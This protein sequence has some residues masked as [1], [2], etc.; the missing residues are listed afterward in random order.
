MATIRFTLRY[1][2]IDKIQSIY[3]VVCVGDYDRLRIKVPNIE[4]HSNQWDKAKG[5]ARNIKEIQNRHEINGLL[6]EMEF[7]ARKAITEIE[8]HNPPA[9]F[10]KIKVAVRKIYPTTKNGKQRPSAEPE[11]EAE[12][13]AKMT[14][15]QFVE[16][17]MKDLVNRV[18]ENGKLTKLQTV[19]NYTSAKNCLKE[20]EV[21]KG[22]TLDFHSFDVP[23]IMEYKSY[24]TTE[25][26]QKPNTIGKKIS[27]IKILLEAAY[28]LDLHSNT[29]YKTKK[30]FRVKSENVDN[31]FMTEK[32]LTTIEN[33]DFSANESLD[34]VRDWF[35]I[36][37]WTGLRYSDFSK[38]EKVLVSN[39]RITIE[40]QKTGQKVTVFLDITETIPKILA[41]RNGNFPKLITNQKFNQYVKDVLR[42]VG[43]NEATI[44]YET[45][46]GKR[47]GTT[48]EK[49]EF[50]TAHTARRTFAT[51][52]Y[53]RRIPITQ[54]MAAT[55]HKSEKEFMKYIK[56]SQIERQGDLKQYMK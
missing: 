23:F 43:I 40:Q 13:A 46:G 14:F 53:L 32:E 17:F 30:E 37:C 7:A 55:G 3:M 25:K 34:N 21:K 39:N 33:H 54:I 35:L 12:T 44:V 5:R 10:E 18:G 45:V 36:G 22:K 28:E 56:A 49:Y 11:K 29:A 52:L 19:K 50:V 24:L 51:N 26:Q 20:F 27:T 42:I 16:K 15:W 48:K 2:K 8:R 31:I 4:V 1:P 9:T 47:V 6:D 41:K 38:L